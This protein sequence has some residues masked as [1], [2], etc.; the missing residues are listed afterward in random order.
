MMKKLILLFTCIFC[1]NTFYAKVKLPCVFTNNAVLQREK[2]IA[3][4]GWANKGEAIKIEF[5]QS[6][7]QALADENGKWKIEML[8]QKAGGPFELKV[9][10]ED[11]EITLR[12]ILI[13]DVWFCAGQSN[14]QMPVADVNNAGAEIAASTNSNI[15]LFNIDKRVQ[16]D[17]PIDEINAVWAECNPSTIRKFSATGYF[18][19]RKIQEVLDIPVGLINASWGSTPAEV[20]TKR[21]L[22]MAD[23]EL[24][25]DALNLEETGS[26]QPYRAG[27]VY[28]A[29][30]YPF[31]LFPLA[32]VIWYQG[33][34][35]QNTAY[36]YEK[37]LTTM[38]KGW[39]ADWGQEL[40]FY[41][42]QICPRY[43]LWEYRTYYASAVIRDQQRR[44][45][46]SLASCELTVNDDIADLNNSHPLNKQDVGLRLAFAALAKT[47]GKSDYTEKLC[48]IYEK[49][50]ILGDAIK[51][52]FKNAEGGLKTSDGQ[53]PTCFEIAG[54]DKAF[55]PA[56]ASIRGNSVLLNSPDVKAPVYVRLG[57]SYYKVT[58]LRNIYELPVS[59]FTTYNFTETDEEPGSKST[60][61]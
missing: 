15:R 55:K 25:T 48:P 4:W 6:T 19:G 27:N 7:Y 43:R 53:S 2:P 11:S 29:M 34:N 12:N 24:K 35:N 30:V 40:P 41:I 61:D 14:M 8:P 33:E 26:K 1:I 49:H 59:I 5:A 3:V 17:V 60:S 56:K 50:K 54:T 52:W 23:E 20:W 16:S 38:I 44:V 42:A 47:Y 51:V 39:R 46:G 32:G 31:R 9:N 57:W 58:N 28:N 18:F 22:V 45:A 21:D 36:H 37:L 10:G 13:G